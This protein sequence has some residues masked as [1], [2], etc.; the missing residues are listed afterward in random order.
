MYG[1]KERFA[2]LLSRTLAVV[3][4]AIH[5]KYGAD[6]ADFGELYLLMALKLT[7]PGG[8]GEI[9]EELRAL[10]LDIDCGF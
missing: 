8:F 4:W 7:E 2:E 9:V 3:Q 5:R 1:E 10:G 6:K